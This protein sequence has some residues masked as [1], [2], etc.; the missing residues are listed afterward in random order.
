MVRPT[1]SD[2]AKS[3]AL[4]FVNALTVRVSGGP[5]FVETIARSGEG[6]V[7]NLLSQ[8]FPEATRVHNRSG[9]S[10]CELNKVL[11]AHGYERVRFRQSQLKRHLPDLAL[12]S[13]ATYRFGNR[14]WRNPHIK[15]DFDHICSVLPHLNQAIGA[16]CSQDT[17]V[18]V[19]NAVLAMEAGGCTVTKATR[20]P[21][22]SSPSFMFE[23]EPDYHLVSVHE[24]L[25]PSPVS[26][27][28]ESDQS[29]ATMS[30]RLASA[31]C[32]RDSIEPV[33]LT[34][35]AIDCFMRES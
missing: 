13:G 2:R 10:R 1:G 22:S 9:V 3:F 11:E 25:S 35:E 17:I 18:S 29:E 32:R 8:C 5:A 6:S 26:S 15:E 28:S 4:S 20:P 16:N 30:P 19:L 23:F 27:L 12:C 24:G 34:V 31:V 14:R 33:P 21:L 7:F